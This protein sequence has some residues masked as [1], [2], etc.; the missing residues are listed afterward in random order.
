MSKFIIQLLLSFENE[1]IENDNVLHF[2]ALR[3]TRKENM[4]AENRELR[5][6]DFPQ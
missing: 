1:P 5:L 3:L 6:V 2:F 4:V